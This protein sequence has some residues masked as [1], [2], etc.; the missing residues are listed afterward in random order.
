MAQQIEEG[1][2]KELQAVIRDAVRE[3]VRSITDQKN[4]TIL[5]LFRPLCEEEDE[6][7][8][9]L[10]TFGDENDIAEYQ[11]SFVLMP[12]G[13]HTIT[14]NNED[15]TSE[16]VNTFGYAELKIADCSFAVKNNIGFESGLAFDDKDRIEENGYAARRGAVCYIDE[17][18]RIYVAVSS[19]TPEQ[20]RECALAGRQAIIDFMEKYEY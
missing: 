3:K 6:W 2:F 4:G 15:G 12:G 5:L 1:S 18:C 16:R 19:L 7:Y 9:G 10:S 8:G 11:V 17:K 13:S 14:Y 20:D